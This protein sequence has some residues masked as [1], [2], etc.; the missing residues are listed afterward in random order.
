M[1]DKNIESTEINLH[2]NQQE[3]LEALTEFL[4]GS[5]NSLTRSVVEGVVD[6]DGN[7]LAYVVD[8]DVFDSVL[9]SLKSTAGN[10]AEILGVTIE[11]NPVEEVMEENDG[12]EK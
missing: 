8:M 1:E 6:D 3:H 7:L 12:N 9:E 5:Y 10:F 2:P 11:E 4:L